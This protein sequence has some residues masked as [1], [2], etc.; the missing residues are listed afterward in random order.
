MEKGYR[1]ILEKYS[2]GTLVS[3]PMIKIVVQDY[4]KL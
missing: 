1:L 3:N 4:A 2:V